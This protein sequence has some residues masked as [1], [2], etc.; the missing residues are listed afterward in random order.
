MRHLTCPKQNQLAMNRFSVILA[1]AS[2]L[3]PLQVTWSQSAPC[4]PPDARAFTSFNNVRALIE[5][6]GSMWQDRKTNSA[7][8]EVPVGEGASTF[9]AGS[10]WLG[11]VSQSGQLSVA[12]NKFSQGTDFYP[13]PLEQ[14]ALQA[15]AQRCLAHDEIFRIRRAD[16]ARH[17]AYHE[18]LA[19]GT[20]EVDFPNGYVTPESILRWPAQGNVLGVV[21]QPL[22]P[23]EDA[24]GD[25]LYTPEEGDC[26]AFSD[27]GCDGAFAD[28]LHGDEVLFWVINDEGVHQESQGEPLGVEIHCQAWGWEEASENLSNTTFYTYKVINRSSNTYSDFYAGWW[29]DAD[30]GTATDDFVGCDVSRGMGYA[31]NGDVID[32]P[33]SSSQGYGE[34]PPATGIDFV[35]GMQED[36]DNQ[37]NPLTEDY[38]EAF[39]N[40]GLMYP[41]AG[42]GFGDDVVDNERRG[43][44][45]FVYYNNSGNPINGEPVIAGHFYNYLRSIWKNGAPMIY[46][47]D[48]VSPATG[49]LEGVFANAMFPGESDPFFWSMGGND[50]GA[51]PWSEVSSGNP[52]ADRRFVMSMGP[53]TLESGASKDFTMA[54]LWARDT[55]EVGASVAALEG[56]SDEVQALFNS[57]FDGL[58]CMDA[59][60][61]NYDPDAVLSAPGVCVAYE[62]GCGTLEA[63]MWQAQ[64]WDIQ[65]AESL[66]A[67]EFGNSPDEFHLVVPSE[68]QG[69]A[70]NDVQLLDVSGLPNGLSLQTAPVYESGMIHCVLLEGAPL[71]TGV[72]ET[73][74]EALATGSNGEE[75]T[76]ELELTLVVSAKPHGGALDGLASY[77]VTKREGRGSG[78]RRLQL[79][80]ESEQVL[81]NSSNGRADEVTYRPGLGPIDVYALPGFYDSANYVVAFT[82]LDDLLAL[83]Y[84]ITNETTGESQSNVFTPESDVHVYAEWGVVLGMDVLEYTS[85][86]DAPLYIH[87]RVV[88]PDSGQWYS[89]HADTEGFSDNNWIRSG[90]REGND[91]FDLLFNDITDCEEVYETALGGTWAPYAVAAYT[92]DNVFYPETGE[93]FEHWPL[94]APTKASLRMLPQYNNP[95]TTT[96]VSVVFTPDKSKWTRSPVLEMQPYAELSENDLG[97]EMEKMFL[98]SHASVDKNGL[99]LSEGGNAS[100]CSLVSGTGMGWFPGY[101][102]DTQTGERLN[103]AFGEDSWLV[104]EN[105][106]DMLFNPGSTSYTPGLLGVF[107][108]GGQH[109]IYVFKNARHFTGAENRMPSYDQGAFIMDQLSNPSISNQRRV[110]RDCAWVGS[111]KTVEGFDWSEGFG[112]TRIQLDAPLPFVAY[113]PSVLDVDDTGSSENNWLPLFAFSTF[114]EASQ[115]E[116]VGSTV[117]LAMTVF[118]NPARDLLTLEIPMNACAERARLFSIR[119]QVV[120]EVEFSEEQGWK[121]VDVRGVPS[122]TY[123]LVV[124][125]TDHMRAAQVVIQH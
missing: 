40:Q 13:G 1:A 116:E 70:V 96:S 51:E 102:I 92:G 3:L 64:G 17:I 20:A 120:H 16:V 56:A 109:W 79:T 119:G 118:P 42:T 78:L 68:S 69:L 55:S 84:T 90:Q 36:P 27:E 121:Q 31:F 72:F 87:S 28:A 76:V 114:D 18:A 80:A 58:G 37:D 44:S 46:G 57:C 54:A 10:L 113:S 9:F 50:P 30:V 63:P 124:E 108:A 88:H 6:R 104:S 7:S 12:A 24:N 100:Q 115:V 123:V 21:G 29:A 75:A 83:P 97:V 98:R 11:G 110:F 61:T 8:Y 99:T 112:T 106:D 66:V 77:P 65:F 105:G 81:L 49:A 82:S 59:T 14:G 52:P 39:S 101:A 107:H 38:E 43:M 47:G 23:F 25:G 85:S 67:L 74:W 73:T 95:Y 117:D 89:G 26:P 91:V 15:D 45:H 103:V 35:L 5:N 34:Y 33:S 2:L 62:Y 86:A 53:V 48:G 4:A 41:G 94:V 71:E 122:G 19:A 111:T 60:A 22:A 125:F 93:T 32:E